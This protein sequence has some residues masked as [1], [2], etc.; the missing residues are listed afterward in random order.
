MRIWDIVDLVHPGVEIT[1]IQKNQRRWSG[2]VSSVA[3][4]VFAVG[5]VVASSATLSVKQKCDMSGSGGSVRVTGIPIAIDN[6]RQS[7]QLGSVSPEFERL[8]LDESLRD[9]SR[10]RL[11]SDEPTHE[12]IG[13]VTGRFS[14]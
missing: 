11:V 8:L 14:D 3:Q 2:I 12:D 6:V 10:F 1:E 9:L 4:G 7:G 13:P 5:L